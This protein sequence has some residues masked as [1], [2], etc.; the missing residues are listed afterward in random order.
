MSIRASTNRTQWVI[1]FFKKKGHEVVREMSWEAEG[2]W[3]EG[4]G[5]NMTKTHFIHVMHFE[6]KKKIDV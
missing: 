2:S 6:N 1:I 3:S 5:M 4:I